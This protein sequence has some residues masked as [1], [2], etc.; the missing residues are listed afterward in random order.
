MRKELL[1]HLEALAKVQELDEIEKMQKQKSI[2]GLVLA[3]EADMAIDHKDMA[4]FRSF[5][6]QCFKC[7][8][9]L[10][11]QIAAAAK[12]LADPSPGAKVRCRVREFSG[13]CICEEPVEA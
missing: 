2:S 4:E 1:E 5:V 7:K 9:Q 10:A 11:A 6:D 8:F 12:I 3:Y 13:A